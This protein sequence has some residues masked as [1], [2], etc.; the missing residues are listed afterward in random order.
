MENNNG[1]FIFDLD[2]ICNFIFTEID[3]A[4]NSEITEIYDSNMNLVNKQIKENKGEKSDANTAIRY[5][6]IK[7][8]V[9][10]ICTAET[11]EMNIGQQVALNTLLSKGF[12]KN[13]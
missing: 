11:E 9:G 8:L 1:G 4:N 13:V 5:D 12:I 2:A 6:I 3:D 7:N 10:L